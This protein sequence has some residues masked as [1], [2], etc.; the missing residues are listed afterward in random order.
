MSARLAA[1]HAAVPVAVRP[2]IRTHP[3]YSGFGHFKK[4][5]PGIKKYHRAFWTEELRNESS[6]SR[7]G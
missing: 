5:K 6:R 7:A 2:T 1:G 4:K 3:L